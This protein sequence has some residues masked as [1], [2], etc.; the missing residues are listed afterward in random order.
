MSTVK[1][2]ARNGYDCSYHILV[3]LCFSLLCVW[4]CHTLH[5]NVTLS[6]I[7]IHLDSQYVESISLD[8]TCFDYKIVYL[9]FGCVCVCHIKC[10]VNKEQRKEKKTHTSDNLIS[11]RYRQCIQTMVGSFAAIQP[12]YQRYIEDNV[13]SSHFYSNT[14]ALVA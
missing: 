1:F 7:P 11:Y 4:I 9:L 14:V 3:D 2:I 13:W 10:D 6:D 12:V 5:T 8:S